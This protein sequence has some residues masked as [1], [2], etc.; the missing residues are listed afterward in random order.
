MNAK[1]Q[2]DG[3][4]VIPELLWYSCDGMM[5]IDENRKVLAMNPTLERLTGRRSEDLT[6]KGECGVLLSCRDLQGCPLAE[7]PD[8]CPGLKA[9]QTM[10]PVRGAE[11]TVRLENGR[12][13][14]MS[15]SYTPIQLPGHPVWALVVLR[16]ITF[17]KKKE[18]QLIQQAKTDPMTQLPNRTAL[19]ETAGKELKRAERHR[20]PLAFGMADTDG[21]KHYNDTY[22]HPAGD[23][24]LKSVAGLLQTG[25][26]SSD[27]IARYGGD[28]FALLLPETDAA[29]AML[30]AERLCMTIA[31][32]PFAHGTAIAM[33]PA[34]SPVTLSV[35]I[36]IFPEDGS[37]V[38]ELL[39]KADGRLYEAKHQGG[40]R[41]IGPA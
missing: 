8:E 21:L 34:V 40:N 18:L 36:A 30:V 39:K 1:L 4:Q 5:V 6:G 37:T 9:M 14:V 15:S 20:R 27:L 33:S 29:G 38:E 35:G 13:V 3:T 31:H 17:Q 10:E 41:V 11:Y 22:G 26:R 19:L 28:E 25:R 2:G 12:S 16:D 23:E 7:T 32:F 24:M